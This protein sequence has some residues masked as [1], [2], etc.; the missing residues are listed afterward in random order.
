MRIFKIKCPDCNAPAMIRK[1]EWKSTQLADLYC[2]CSEVECGHTFVFN[3]SYS[4]TLSPSGLKNSN[5]LVSFL[6]ERLKPE[7]RQMAL[8]LLQGQNR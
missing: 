1:T 2:A 3:V 4:H 7:E 6:I 5:K 8:N